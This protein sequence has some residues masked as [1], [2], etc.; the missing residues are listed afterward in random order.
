[1]DVPKVQSLQPLQPLAA[2]GVEMARALRR[3]QVSKA[4][5]IQLA[6]PAGLKAMLW[7][8]RQGYEQAMLVCGEGAGSREPADV[9]LIPHACGSRELAELL[10]AGRGV[11]EGGVLIVQVT[12][13]ESPE[14][15]AI[16]LEPL[17]Y[18]VEHRLF[19]NGRTVLIA[20]RFALGAIQEAA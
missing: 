15:A 19:D 14:A 3:A 1:M 18:R 8:C 9:L 16:M 2:D 6:G 10:N 20:R 4:D 11:H 13:N 5:V 7:L 17:G 12:A